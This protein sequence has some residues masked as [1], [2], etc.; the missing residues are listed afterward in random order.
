VEV[1][2]DVPDVMPFLA[3]ASVMAVPLEAGGGTRLKILEA[4]AAGLPVVATRV[5]GEGIEAV[6]G[7]HVWI[8]ERETF[9]PAVLDLL[10]HGPMARARAER[11]RALVEHRYDWTAIGER[12][13]DAVEDAITGGSHD[14]RR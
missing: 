1:H 12:A 3:A 11:A 7:E 5:G 2:A 14:Q 8:A 9:A 13:C 6:D 4:F 10:R